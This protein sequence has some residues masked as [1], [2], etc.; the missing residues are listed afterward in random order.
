VR[1]PPCPNGIAAVKPRQ[2]VDLDQTSSA[3]SANS[4]D[5]NLR[6]NEELQAGANR[7][8]KQVRLKYDLVIQEAVYQ[9]QARHHRKVLAGLNSASKPKAYPVSKSLGSGSGPW[10]RIDHAPDCPLTGWRHWPR[11][12]QASCQWRR[13]RYAKQIAST[14]ASALIVPLAMRDVA[15]GAACIV[16]LD[17]ICILPASVVASTACAAGRPSG[18]IGQHPS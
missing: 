5:L 9:P 1:R 4:E 18:T 2:L 8:I 15:V 16:T 13:H 3:S 10:R 17:P 6:K 7:V 14:Q 12:R 11:R